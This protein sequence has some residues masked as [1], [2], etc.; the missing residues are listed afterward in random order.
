L[1]GS[2]PGGL[3]E[4]AKTTAIILIDDSQ[5]MTGSDEG[6]ELL[7]QAK[8]AAIAITNFLKE[9]DE[10]YLVKLSEVT[11]QGTSEI[12]SAQRD[13][14]VIQ[15]NI[16]EI[17][18]SSIHRSI[19]DALRFTARLLT[20][21]KNFNKE[22]YVISDFQS[23]SL[24]SKMNISKTAEQLFTPTTRFFIIPLGKRKLQNVSVESIEIPNSIFEVN[25]PFIVKAQ[26]ANHGALDVQNHMVSVYQSGSRVAQKGVDIRAGQSIETEFTL[27]SSHS[28]FV[29]GTI[30][31]ED[32]DLEF[33][34]K[35]YFTIHI[36]E[37]LRVLLV[38]STSD[39]TYIR[40]ALTAQLSD[41]ITNLKTTETTF[42]RFSSSQLNKTDVV[43]LS[44]P[45]ELTTI[46]TV[47]L[48]MFLQ[49]GGGVFI[50]PGSQTTANLFNT[51]VASPLGI[52][53]ITQ[54]ENQPSSIHSSNTFFEFDKV[55]YRHPLFAG[56]FEE[57]IAN[58]SLGT[59]HRQRVL[60]S[61]SI[62]ISLHFLPTPRSQSIITLTDGYPF[63]LEERIGNGRVLLL[64]VAANTEWSNLPL[65][66]LFVPLLHR[67]LVYLAQE[68]K[69][70]YSLLAGEETTIRLRTSVP[71]K[72]TVKKPDG[73]EVFVNTQQ[74]VVE[75]RMRFS[76][77]DETGIYTMETGNLVLDKFAVNIDPDELD[78]LPSN[79]NRLEKIMHQLGITDKMVYTVNQ[80]LDMQHIITESRLGTEL[81]KQF[82]IA[83]LIVA[84]I[85]MFVA[86]ERGWTFD[87]QQKQNSMRD[88]V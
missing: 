74:S 15:N 20:A 8:Y 41:S 13:I 77:T 40:F 81:W 28:G 26:L 21:S 52:S 4:Q 46:Q 48:K 87:K 36:P 22:I 71:P 24:E 80:P 54:S 6:G 37:E 7:H 14:Q 25:K 30:E 76:T 31:L 68:P 39:L 38:G 42:N 43:V 60:E 86:R 70:I 34:N 1:K 27:V 35:R 64:S 16:N 55:D 85:E 32:D 78:I 47:A 51:T 61:P 50:I 49:N 10:A 63:L 53:A 3:A 66:G 29:E 12:P 44:N 19:E 58:K 17:K 45:Q 33:D 84:I 79:E 5:S 83:A 11:V 72:I 88:H 65:K 9:G 82:L 23:G 69:N 75:N 56:M 67:S 18:P 73:K 59:T 57:T 2:L 62:Y